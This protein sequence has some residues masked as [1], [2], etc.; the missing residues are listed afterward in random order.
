MRFNNPR[1]K[2][3]QARR[4]QPNQN[5][6][7]WESCARSAAVPAAAAGGAIKDLGGNDLVDD[8]VGNYTGAGREIKTRMRTRNGR[9]GFSG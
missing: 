9:K 1:A 8:G 3:G 5:G 6:R 7:I 4:V 2:E